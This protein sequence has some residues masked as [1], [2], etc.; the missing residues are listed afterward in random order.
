MQLQIRDR[1]VHLELIAEPKLDELV[2]VGL[3]RFGVRLFAVHQRGREVEIA[4]AASKDLE[5]VAVW[6][7][8]AL[9]RVFWIEAPDV[10]SERAWARAG[11]SVSERTTPDGRRRIFALGGDSKAAGS[12]LSSR[13]TIDYPL[14]SADLEGTGHSVS[15]RNPWCGYEALI[16]PVRRP[17]TSTRS[18]D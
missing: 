1:D 7:L 10:A 2:V 9:H 8:D 3:A 12:A 17:A 4:G 13:V 11:E 15:I 18:R 6:A 16:V 14:P 5:Q